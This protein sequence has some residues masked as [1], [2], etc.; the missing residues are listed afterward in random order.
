MG[1]FNLIDGLWVV[2]IQNRNPSLT[3]PNQPRRNTIGKSHQGETQYGQAGHS[4]HKISA[5]VESMREVVGV[6]GGKDWWI[7]SGDRSMAR[8]EKLRTHYGDE[9][10]VRDL[11]ERGPKCVLGHQFRLPHGDLELPDC[12]GKLTKPKP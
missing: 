8:G 4:S 5:D 11:Q 9:A 6:N 12:S 7:I 2:N 3:I 1:V 10:P